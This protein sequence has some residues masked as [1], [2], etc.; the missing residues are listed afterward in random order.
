MSLTHLQIQNLRNIQSARLDFHPHLNLIEG[1]NGS[2]KT[3]FLE[4]IY[5][6]GCGHSFRT[7]EIS[8][9]IQYGAEHLTV[10]ART[11][12]EQTVS[13]QKSRFSLPQVRINALPC[14][15][16]STLAYFLPCQVF[17]QDVFQIID[18]GPAA[19]RSVL[20]WGLFH[21]KQ[22]YHSFWKD[23]RRA[24]KQRNSLLRQKA[25]RQQLYPWDKMLVELSEQF[26]Q[27]RATYF[28]QLNR[29]FKQVLSQLMD[30]EINLAYYK[31]WDRRNTGKALA[32]ILADSYEGDSQRQY[33]QYGAHQADLFIEGH[34]LQAKNY[35]SRGQQKLVLFALKLAQA[36]I[37]EK[38]CIYLCDDLSAEL[39]ENHIIKVFQL[40]KKTQ[41]Q[42]FITT[43]N[44]K[45]LFL[46]QA[47]IDY[48]HFKAPFSYFDNLTISEGLENS[49]E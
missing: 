6:L 30:D 44:H 24:L 36:Q 9:L 48:K 29:V 21:V 41:G 33:T 26:D 46:D 31:G 34:D 27:I 14:Q 18:A 28:A 43:V 12:D 4:A 32:T 22:S 39:D 37:M 20:D 19:R 3:S 23:Y 2:G 35:L 49:N 5:L 16:S 10:F 38:K 15:T 25:G 40:I 1:N 11:E 42:F 45:A 47:N 7:R 8:P 17:Y 13:I